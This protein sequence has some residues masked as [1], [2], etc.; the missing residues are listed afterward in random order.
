MSGLVLLAMSS[1]A[2][3][4]PHAWDE[5]YAYET[6]EPE[7]EHAQGGPCTW[8]DEMRRVGVAFR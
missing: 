1:G 8:L 6:Y 3:P 4:D 2:D 7:P 5:P